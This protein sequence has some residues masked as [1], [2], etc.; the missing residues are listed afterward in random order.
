MAFSHPFSTEELRLHS[1]CSIWNRTEVPEWGSWEEEFCMGMGA[2]MKLCSPGQRCPMEHAICLEP[3]MWK[4]PPGARKQIPKLC[5]AG[6]WDPIL[7][8]VHG[9]EIM[10]WEINLKYLIS[11]TDKTP[12]RLVRGK[13]FSMLVSSSPEPSKTPVENDSHQ[14]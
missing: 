14:R 11:E 4:E 13:N 10:N 8:F 6:E 2:K 9:E 7:N 3:W 12:E 5:S 1:L